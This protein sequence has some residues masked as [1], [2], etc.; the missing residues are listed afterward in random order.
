MPHSTAGAS[1]VPLTS[2][3]D[4]ADTRAPERRTA[5]WHD[6]GWREAVFVTPL[7]PWLWF[8]VRSWHPTFEFVA[9][10]LPVILLFG[11][12]VAAVLAAAR[13]SVL[14]LSIVVSLAA[15]FIVAVVLPWRPSNGPAPESSF[16]VATM[17]AGLYFF[18]DNDAGYFVNRHEPDLLVGVELTE[19]HDTEFRARF[20]NAHSDILPLERQQQNEQGLEPVGDTYRRNGLPS[21][22]VYSRFEMTV[23]DDPLAESFPGGLPGFRLE[24]ATDEGPMIVYA[25][26]VPRPIPGE[27]PYELSASAHVDLVDQIADAVERETLPVVV[28]GDFNAVDRGQAYR[29]LTQSLED[30]MRHAGWAV[31]TADRPLP[32]SLIFA[33]LDHIF[34]TSDLCTTNALSEDTRFSDHRPLVADIGP[35]PRQ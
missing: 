2:V 8:V 6:L 7:V 34:M 26:H 9:I 20:P 25:L 29:R 32:W 21:I 10:L 14:W 35:C 15:M 31:P 13:R 17:N 18:S 23:L 4:D 3:L 11:I 33:R 28:L 27:G 30:G 16:R 24:V 19:A 5:A 12:G 1:S 22:G